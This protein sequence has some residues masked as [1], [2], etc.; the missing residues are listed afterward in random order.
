MRITVNGQTLEVAAPTLALLLDELGYGDK[1]VATAVN[2]EFVR[3]KDRREVLLRE[4]DT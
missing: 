1:T 2:Q 4:D 3:G